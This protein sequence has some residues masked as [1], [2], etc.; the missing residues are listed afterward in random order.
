MFSVWAQW[1]HAFQTCLQLFHTPFLPTFVEIPNSAGY[2]TLRNMYFPCYGRKNEISFLEKES[3]P[4]LLEDSEH[5]P[6]R[7]RQFKIFNFQLMPWNKK[8]RNAGLR[9][10]ALFLTES[11][12]DRQNNR[13]LTSDEGPRFYL[14]RLSQEN[15][16]EVGACL[17]FCF[18]W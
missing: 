10:K 11:Q 1:A 14:P 12:I 2:Q 9:R 15:L 5:P 3:N 13:N 8:D 7:M 18:F 16:H 4:S 17:I 6:N